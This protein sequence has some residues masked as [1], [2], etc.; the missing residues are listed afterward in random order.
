MTIL[1]AALCD[2]ATDYGGKLN[3]LG[4][5][6]TIYA[7]NLPAVHPNCAVAVR[8]VVTRGEEGRHGLVVNFVDDDGSPV[9]PSL[10]VGVQVHIP[11]EVEML[12]RN[13]VFNI[14]QLRFNRA[15]NF[16]I[17]IAWDGHHSASIPLRVVHIRRDEPAEEPFETAESIPQ[18][19]VS[20]FGDDPASDQIDMDADTD[21]MDRDRDLDTDLDDEEG[22]GTGA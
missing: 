3:I 22:K 16:A 12:S 14:Q 1:I 8:I 19:D 10:R 9:M 15:G 21:T 4:A 20:P 11:E 7:A 18:D 5:F 13:F 2:A 6:D 17:D